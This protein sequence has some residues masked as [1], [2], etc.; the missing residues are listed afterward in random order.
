MSSLGTL[1]VCRCNVSLG[2]LGVSRCGLHMQCFVILCTV[3]NVAQIYVSEHPHP[4]LLVCLIISSMGRK[5]KTPV[6][7]RVS[8]RSNWQLE[9]PETQAS[10]AAE[11]G[12]TQELYVDASPA[13]E[14]GGTEDRQM[15]VDG[16]TQ[17]DLSTQQ[18][19]APETQAESESEEPEEQE[20]PEQEKPEEQEGH[21]QP[22]EQE[23]PEACHPPN[24]QI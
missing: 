10:P 20:E 6:S 23:E 24:P 14:I 9:F 17:I 19:F 15:Y 21:E 1:G 7:A 22:E 8:S 3:P 12:G 18:C 5:G 2:S 16:D 11:I 4:F 13:A